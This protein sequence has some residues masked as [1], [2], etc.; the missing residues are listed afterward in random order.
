MEAIKQIGYTS[1]NVT[2]IINRR[3]AAFQQRDGNFDPRRARP[4]RRALAGCKRW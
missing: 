4:R 1:E 2:E 3:F